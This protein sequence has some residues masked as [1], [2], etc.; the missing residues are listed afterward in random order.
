MPADKD[1]K[2][3]EGVAEELTRAV[4][5]EAA[6]VPS[7]EKKDAAEGVDAD[8]AT[9][10]P[11]AEPMK[12]PQSIWDATVV[13]PASPG[14][15]RFMPLLVRPGARYC[16]VCGHEYCRFTYSRWEYGDMAE[17]M[18]DDHTTHYCNPDPDANRRTCNHPKY[19]GCIRGDH[20]WWSMGCCKCEG[21]P[22]WQS[23]DTKPGP[24]GTRV[25]G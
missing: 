16:D 25:R 17:G 24:N 22:R 9:T 21:W 12:V 23:P 7:P 18:A 6:A 11:E 3:E 10:P 15:L 14:D 2:V 13:A 20:Y 8:A 4:E 1:G 19:D 5:E